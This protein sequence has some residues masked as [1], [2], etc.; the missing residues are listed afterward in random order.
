VIQIPGHVFEVSTSNLTGSAKEWRGTG[1]RPVPAVVMPPAEDDCQGSIGVFSN[2]GHAIEFRASGVND[3]GKKAAT[4]VTVSWVSVSEEGRTIAKPSDPRV[5][6]VALASGGW[7]EKRELE[8]AVGVPPNCPVTVEIPESGW[9][10]T[11]DDGLDHLMV[12]L[13]GIRDN[14]STPNATTEGGGR[15]R[16][17]TAPPRRAPV[18]TIR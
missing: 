11:E 9:S 5:P 3:A 14:D 18:R 10:G 13:Y 16:A 8:I 2:N 7:P 12:N 17:P 6:Y 1:E 4:K 15:R